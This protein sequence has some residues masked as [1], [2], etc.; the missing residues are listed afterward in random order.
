MKTGIND[1]VL[2]A[3]EEA[4]IRRDQADHEIRVLI[5]YARELI[6][7]RP[8]RLTD[9]A[10][11]AGMSVSGVRTAYA[12]EHIEIAQRRGGDAQ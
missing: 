5:A 6:R 2:A 4:R 3:I 10:T 12:R 8:Y 7:P 11:A 9:L 1:P